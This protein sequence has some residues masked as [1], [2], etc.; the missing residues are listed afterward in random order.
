MGIL[1][2]KIKV[3]LTINIDDGYGYGSGD[4][5]GDGYGDGSGYGNGDGSGYGYGDG[6]GYGNGDGSGYGNG[7]G[8]GDGSG[9]GYGNGYGDGSG[10]GNGDGIKTYKNKTV[11]LI[12]EVATIITHVYQN[13][14]KGY[15]LQSTLEIEPCYIAKGQNMFAHGETAKKAMQALQEKIFE[16]MDTEETIEKFREKFKNNRKYK[17]N[18]F[19]LWHHILTGSC[20]M[21]R[22]NFVKNHELDL[23]K[24]YSVKE[25][26]ELTENDYG[27]EIIQQLKEFYN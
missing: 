12:D 27:G 17:G 22:D 10:Y 6:S 24:M 21:G 20:E 25:F 14:A 23:N 1:E 5:S 19:Y 7:D 11:Y 16:N 15:I 3:F 8:S 13:L 4:G 18:T 26:I 2:D 9:Y